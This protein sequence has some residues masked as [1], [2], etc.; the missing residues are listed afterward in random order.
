VNVLP[1]CSPPHAPSRISVGRFYGIDRLL[2]K[3]VRFHYDFAGAR[4]DFAIEEIFQDHPIS[5]N[6]SFFLLH[7]I[8]LANH[9][10]MLVP[11]RWGRM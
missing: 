3:T 9:I 2:G 4:G 7:C 8:K 11:W 10:A 6:L 5:V 1:E